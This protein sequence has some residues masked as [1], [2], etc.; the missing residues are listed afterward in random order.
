[1][2]TLVKMQN[3]YLRN[4]KRTKKMMKRQKKRKKKRNGGIKLI[5]LLKLKI[6]LLKKLKKDLN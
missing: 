2:T 6:Y 4:S 3:N 5:E 1:M